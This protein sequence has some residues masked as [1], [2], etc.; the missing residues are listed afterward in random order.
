MRGKAAAARKGLNIKAGT[1]DNPKFKRLVRAL[2]RIGETRQDLGFAVA[3]QPVAIAMAAGVLEVMWQFTAKYA[4]QGDIGRW[5]DEDIAE[6]VGWPVGGAPALV[7]A[8]VEERWLDRSAEHR[9]LVHD[10]PEHCEDGVH[11]KLARARKW[12]GDGTPPKLNRLEKDDRAELARFYGEHATEGVVRAH[13]GARRAHGGAEPSL[14]LALA[15]PCEEGGKGQETPDTLTREAAKL[16]ETIPPGGKFRAEYR[17]LVETGRFR[18]LTYEHF[19]QVFHGMALDPTRYTPHLVTIAASMTPE[20]LDRMRK[21]PES[22]WIEFWLKDRLQFEETPAGRVA[23]AQGHKA[24]SERKRLAQEVKAAAD[25]IE[26]KREGGGGQREDDGA[27]ERVRDELRRRYGEAAVEALSR[28]LEGRKTETG[29]EHG[30]A[31]SR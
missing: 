18:V 4:P 16:L 12:F 26:W 19:R 14:L 22:R 30:K 31:G 7:E 6:A 17:A 8:L 23:V 15:K 13:G 11:M 21:H 25:L 2:G 28:E 5:R 1:L 3:G 24:S 9:L 29:D 10:W 27:E 20:A